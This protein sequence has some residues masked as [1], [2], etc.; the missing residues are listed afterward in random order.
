MSFESTSARNALYRSM[1]RMTPSRS[2]WRSADVISIAASFSAWANV[3]STR[4]CS[5]AD[6]FTAC[7]ARA[8]GAIGAI[9]TK[10]SQER[11]RRR[12]TSDADGLPCLLRNMSVSGMIA[13]NALMEYE[14]LLIGGCS[15]PW[16]NVGG[17]GDN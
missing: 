2:N 7:A 6:V 12:P 10:G 3:D 15:E 5:A 16:A 11:K 8:S 4:S 9:G 17:F 13:W 1:F 14:L